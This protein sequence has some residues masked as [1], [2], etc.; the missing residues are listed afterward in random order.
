MDYQNRAGSKKGAAGIASDAQANLARKKQVEELLKDGE[1]IPYTFQDEEVQDEKL[2][3]N[4]YIYKNHSGK[5]ICKLC[6]TMHVSW[7]SVE[8]H[9]SGKKHGLNVLRRGN[10]ASKGDSHER[11]GL[12][13]DRDREFQRE[14]LQRRENLKNAGL[15]PKCTVVNVQGKSNDSYGVAIRVDYNVEE[16]ASLDLS[17]LEEKLSPMIRIMSGLELHEADKKDKKYVVIAYEPFENVAVEIP[18]DKSIAMN[19]S[20]I[21]TDAIDDVN[22]KCTFWDEDNRML[23]IQFF[24]E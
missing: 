6:N 9:L 18:S 21:V 10:T 12:Q 4:P 15:V 20:E 17:V 19:D 5:L 2:R 22:S 11:S 23:Y 13:D 7:S 3:K 1:Q 8:R 16:S 14:V 24:L